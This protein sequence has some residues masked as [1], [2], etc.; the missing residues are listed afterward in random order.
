[1]R[2]MAHQVT[3]LTTRPDNLSF[4]NRIHMTERESKI[5]QAVYARA[6]THTHNTNNFG[7]EEKGSVAKSAYCSCGGSTLGS[8]HSRWEV[9]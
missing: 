4:I 8:R 6:H 9:R 7:A 3:A 2:E 1:M 5:T